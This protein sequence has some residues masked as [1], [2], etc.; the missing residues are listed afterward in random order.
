MSLFFS[1]SAK[2]STH[3]PVVCCCRE[4]VHLVH[5]QELWCLG[6]CDHHDHQAVPVYPSVITVF[7]QPSHTWPMVST[8]CPR[9]LRRLHPHQLPSC[10]TG[11][12]GLSDL[13]DMSWDS[14]P[15]ASSH[16]VDHGQTVN[17]PPTQWHGMPLL[18]QRTMQRCYKQLTIVMPHAHQTLLASIKASI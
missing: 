16:V 17:L 5:H 11:I 3:M 8:T 10:A 7:W 9:G 14:R 6:V 4:P 13:N 15:G 1:I 2:R 12:V 18:H